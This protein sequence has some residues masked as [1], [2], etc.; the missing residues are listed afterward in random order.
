MR[1]QYQ[2][3][4]KR[5]MNY[6]LKQKWICTSLYSESVRFGLCWSQDLQEKVIHWFSWP[7]TCF[8]VWTSKDNTRR[9]TWD[10]GYYIQRCLRM[11]KVYWFPREMLTVALTPNSLN[12][13]RWQLSSRK[14]HVPGNHSSDDGKVGQRVRGRPFHQE[15]LGRAQV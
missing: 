15:S 4:K 1:L 13:L 3:E 14:P 7:P 2:G 11:C 12:M 6:K 10:E 9:I 8:G 5:E